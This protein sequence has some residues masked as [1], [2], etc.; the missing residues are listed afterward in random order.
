RLEAARQSEQLSP[1]SRLVQRHF[2]RFQPFAQLK[3]LLFGQL[4]AETADNGKGRL[5][6]LVQDVAERLQCLPSSL[7]DFLRRRERDEISADDVILDTRVERT[8]IVQ[9]VLPAVGSHDDVSR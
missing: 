3:N 7:G 9:F 8:M 4:R 1:L 2:Q 5:A 6:A